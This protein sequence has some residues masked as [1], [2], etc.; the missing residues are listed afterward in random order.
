V[1]DVL[2]EGPEDEAED[3]GEPLE[4]QRRG[5]APSI[6]LYSIV[7][8]APLRIVSAANAD[9]A[10]VIFGR[11]KRNASKRSWVASALAGALLVAASCAGPR[12]PGLWAR[13]VEHVVAI[14]RAGT[15][16]LADGRAALTTDRGFDVVVARAHLVQAQA[17][18]V[19]C[20]GVGSDVWDDPL[21]LGRWLGPTIA[22]AGHSESTEPS[23]VTAPRAIDL[24]AGAARTTFGR[25][26]FEEQRYCRSHFLVA[27]IDDTALVADAPADVDLAGLSLYVEAQVMGERPRAITIATTLSDGAITDLPE[28]LVGGL[29]GSHA[30]LTVTRR[31]AI[32]FDGLDLDDPTLTDDAIARSLLAQLDHDALVTLEVTEEAP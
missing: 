2:E 29:E 24:V 30:T 25:A 8:Q 22:Y 10:R 19:D 16:A 17:Q 5:H 7:S 14:D 4:H 15:R 13:S 26:S 3:E 28:A 21:A 27:G 20:A 9:A 6:E 23:A 11:V 1:K 12:E 32:A 31:L 18:L